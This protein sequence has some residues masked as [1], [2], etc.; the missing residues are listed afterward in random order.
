MSLQFIKSHSQ[1]HFLSEASKLTGQS[2]ESYETPGDIVS[3]VASSTQSILSVVASTTPALSNEN[4]DAFIDYFDPRFPRWISIFLFIVGLFGNTLCLVVFMQKNMRKNSTFIYLAF[5]SVVDLMVLLLGLG[6]IILISYFHFNVR[7]K[8][9]Y[10]CRFVSFLIYGSTHLS[11]FIL[12]SVSI[13]RAIATN[14]INYAKEY[15][16]PVMAYKIILIN[17]AIASFLDFHNLF[18]LVSMHLW[19]E[20]NETLFSFK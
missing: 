10:L 14:F 11:S 7:A 1:V 5:L 8:S 13:D 6:D 15:C 19:H 17:I 20:S 12:A 2:I 9:I 18:F 4:N 16:K 3:A